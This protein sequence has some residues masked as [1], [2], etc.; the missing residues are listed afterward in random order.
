MINY[1]TDMLVD[2][3]VCLDKAKKAKGTYVIDV[4]CIS[5]RKIL[6]YSG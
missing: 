1:V 3:N 6:I 5:L 4:M 2:I